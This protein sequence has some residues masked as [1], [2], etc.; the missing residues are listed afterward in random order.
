MKK[1]IIHLFL[2]FSFRMSSSLVII[3]FPD[4]AWPHVASQHVGR[5]CKI[6]PLQRGKT[7]INECPA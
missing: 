2:F 1:E 3:L 5:S 7:P 6:R 4:N